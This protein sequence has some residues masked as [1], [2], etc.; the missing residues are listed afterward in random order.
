MAGTGQAPSRPVSS[1]SKEVPNSSRIRIRVSTFGR[2]CPRSYRLICIQATPSSRWPNSACVRPAFCRTALILLPIVAF[3]G[4]ST[5]YS[6]TELAFL[7]LAL[8]ILA[9]K[10]L[11]FDGCASYQRQPTG[12]LS[13]PLALTWSPSVPAKPGPLNTGRTGVTLTLRV[14]S[15]R[16]ERR[17]KE[18]L[19]HWW[20]PSTVTSAIPSAGVPDV[21]GPSG[22]RRSSGHPSDR[23]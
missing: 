21:P 11:A 20:I 23:P 8:E 17:H 7:R 6:L 13:A 9:L 1:R 2:V 18:R 22:C 10:K 16:S 19:N 3:V 5:K 14:T 15:A 4:R 12:A